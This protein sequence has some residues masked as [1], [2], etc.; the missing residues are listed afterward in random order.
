MTTEEIQAPTFRVTPTGITARRELKIDWD[1]VDSFIDN[2]AGTTVAAGTEILRVGSSK[3][4]GKDHLILDEITVEPFIGPDN[5]RENDVNGV[6]TSEFARVFLDYRT[7]SYDQDETSDTSDQP[8]DLPETTYITYEANGSQQEITHSNWALGWEFANDNSKHT[9]PEDAKPGFPISIIDHTITWHKVPQPPWATIYSTLG[10]TNNAAFLGHPQDVVLFVG[11]NATRQA[12]SEG[13]R[14]WELRYNFKA[15]II[16]GAQGVIGVA[17]L[18]DTTDNP[19]WNH[20]LRPDPA[21]G[22]PPWHRIR[23]DPTSADKPLI[24]QADFST[25]FQAPS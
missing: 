5:V 25:L 2:N 3:F 14:Q 4:P 7:L 23:I 19:G 12:T 10:K 16:H 8:D 1:E 15:R 18:K 24:D 21:A 17:G 9:L 6:A 22:D 13:L 20:F 11:F